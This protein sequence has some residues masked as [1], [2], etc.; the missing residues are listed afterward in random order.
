MTAMDTLPQVSLTLPE[1]PRFDD[2]IVDMRE[3]IRTM[4]ESL[5]NEIMD[6]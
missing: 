6:V 4:K 3:L 2:G 1:M 5:A